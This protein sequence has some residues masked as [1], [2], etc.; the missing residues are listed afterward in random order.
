[1]KIIPSELPAVCVIC[2]TDQTIATSE[3]QWI[4]TPR[5]VWFFILLGILPALLLSFL[6]RVKHDILLPLCEKCTKRRKWRDA[7]SLL[8]LTSCALMLLVGIG[9][10]FAASEDNLQ[11]TFLGIIGILAL[12][13]A[14]AIAYLAQKFEVSIT[15]QFPTY[16]K[17]RVEI[18]VPGHGVSVLFDKTTT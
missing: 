4:R 12:T 15:P 17:E 1:M 18:N 13:M 9:F 5:W 8:A 14:G 6:V 3:V 2:G 16:T 11:S 7:V 10:I